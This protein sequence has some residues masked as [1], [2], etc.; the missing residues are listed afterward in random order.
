[1]ILEEKRERSLYLKASLLFLRKE[2]VYEK[3][4]NRTKQQNHSLL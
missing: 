4:I 3:R 1:M 2:W